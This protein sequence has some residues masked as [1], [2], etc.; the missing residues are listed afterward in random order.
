[1]VQITVKGGSVVFTAP[2]HRKVYLMDLVNNLGYSIKDISYVEQ[3][4]LV[5]YNKKENPNKRSNE[6]V[7]YRRENDEKIV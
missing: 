4:N 2:D 3:D 1:M 5:D 6:Y 7:Y